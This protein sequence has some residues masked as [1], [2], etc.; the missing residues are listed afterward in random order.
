MVD[1]PQLTA[2]DVACVPRSAQ[3][4]ATRG[5]G[6]APSRKGAGKG[7][8]VPP[9]PP[10][11][12]GPARRQGA[13]AGQAPT[14]AHK[15]YASKAAEEA[16]SHQPLRRVIVRGMDG[17]ELE[18]KVQLS[19]LVKTAKTL[20]GAEL[21]AASGERGSVSAARIRLVFGAR[22]LLNFSTMESNGVQDGSVLMLIM[23]PP[24]Y[25]QLDELGV[26]VPDDVLAKKA[27]LHDD[28]AEAG[29]LLRPR[30]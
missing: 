26:N 21:A 4:D 10:R 3:P 11:S 24:I 6:D 16:K 1:S 13:A 30:W 5:G 19:A 22:P 29:R 9:P 2:D 25:G 8:S 14:S 23:L 15:G 27:Q 18:I 20:V 12:S 17:R 7:K 28:L